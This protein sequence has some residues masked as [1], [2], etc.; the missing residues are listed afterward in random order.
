MPYVYTFAAL[1]IKKISSMQ[2]IFKIHVVKFSQLF[3]V[4]LL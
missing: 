4:Y 1:Q 3:S 2:G